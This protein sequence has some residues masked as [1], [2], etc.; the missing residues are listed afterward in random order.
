[1]GPRK[2]VPFVG[3]GAPRELG[4]ADFGATRCGNPFSPQ[5]SLASWHCL[6]RIRNALRIRQKYSF[7]FC[8]AARRSGL[9]RR[10]APRNDRGEAVASLQTLTPCK[11]LHVIASQCAHWRGNPRP[12]AESW[13]IAAVSGCA[14]TCRVCH[15][16]PVRTPA[17]IRFPAG[18]PGKLAVARANS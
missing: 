9:P 3:R 1:M 10:F 4:M 2:G 18:K 15:C 6:G 7:S 11:F 13:Y 12:L 8:T 5:G 17:A 16:A 14:H